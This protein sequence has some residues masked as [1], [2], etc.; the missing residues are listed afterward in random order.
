MWLQCGLERCSL[1]LPAPLLELQAEI[2]VYCEL[3]EEGLDP[4]CA[5]F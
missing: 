2:L 4:S 3:R 1:G 5:T